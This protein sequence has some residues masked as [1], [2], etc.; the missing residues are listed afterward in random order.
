MKTDTLINI[1]DFDENGSVSIQIPQIQSGY[2]L[3]LNHWDS[4]AIQLNEIEKDLLA[5]DSARR[6]AFLEKVKTVLFEFIDCG[7]F[8][9]EDDSSEGDDSFEEDISDERFDGMSD[10]EFEK[11]FKEVL[12]ENAN[13]EW[14]FGDDEESEEEK[15]YNLRNS[16]ASIAIEATY[17]E[18]GCDIECLTVYNYRLKHSL[19]WYMMGRVGNEIAKVKSHIEVLH[20]LLKV[21]DDIDGFIKILRES[22]SPFASANNIMKEFGLSM[23]QA[24]AILRKTLK[25]LTSLDED[26]I[27]GQIEGF[28]EIISFLEKLR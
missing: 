14:D 7:V 4:V 25:E 15:E 26:Y 24:E 18:D 13:K 20:G 9:Y 1:V 5:P 27:I 16:K 3:I 23:P 17:D 12:G 19:G 2:S 28:T 10:S 6:R 22:N 21:I 11:Y 8:T